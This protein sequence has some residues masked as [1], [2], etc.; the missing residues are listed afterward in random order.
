MQWSHL[1]S[2]GRRESMVIEAVKIQILPPHLPKKKCIKVLERE[3][4]YIQAGVCIGK[5]ENVERQRRGSKRTI[6]QSCKKLI[7]C[8]SGETQ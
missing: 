4:R 3:K 5:R 7:F 1:K 8:V 6:K 2:R